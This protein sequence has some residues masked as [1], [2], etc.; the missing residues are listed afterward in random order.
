MVLCV[1]IVGMS[2][3]TELM[4]W[5][6]IQDHKVH[7]SNQ[8]TDLAGFY[9][10]RLIRM[11]ECQIIFEVKEEE[12]QSYLFITEH[13]TVAHH[14]CMT[15]KA[16]SWTIEVY[17]SQVLQSKMFSQSLFRAGRVRK[18]TVS[19]VHSSVNRICTELN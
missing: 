9:Y 3:T 2:S 15:T 17:Q 19:M 6:G 7:T 18:K 4:A 1:I 10:P 12:I 13:L 5:T 14:L 8:D 11:N 16:L